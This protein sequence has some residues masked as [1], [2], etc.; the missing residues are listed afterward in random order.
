[1]SF[2]SSSS[3]STS[4]NNG[5]SEDD[6][7]VRAI[8]REGAPESSSTIQTPVTTIHPVAKITTATPAVS[9]TH[10]ISGSN[11]MNASSSCSST[12]TNVT[13]VNHVPESAARWIVT[14]LVEYVQT[15]SDRSQTVVALETAFV[16]HA[17][18][19]PPKVATT[20]ES[21]KLLVENI[22]HRFSRAD[23]YPE[24]LGCLKC[25]LVNI[26]RCL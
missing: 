2:S 14:Q 26:Y 9:A 16:Q 24:G 13:S 25:K 21:A 4:S 7:K 23:E 20:K 3:T 5:G 17:C 6:G 18:I 15:L 10:R 12:S 19:C 11:G 8:T 22:I 1:M